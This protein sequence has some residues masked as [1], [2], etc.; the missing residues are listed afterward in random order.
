MRGVAIRSD[1]VSAVCI[2]DQHSFI[3]NTHILGTSRHL[4]TSETRFPHNSTAPDTLDV[5]LR[6][7]HHGQYAEYAP[8]DC[9]AQE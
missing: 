3:H 5:V 1:E 2:I 6:G 7:E 9:G 4:T 8:S